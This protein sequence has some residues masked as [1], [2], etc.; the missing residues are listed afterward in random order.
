MTEKSVQSHLCMGLTGLGSKLTSRPAPRVLLRLNFP[1]AGKQSKRIEDPGPFPHKTS[2]ES[3]ILQS[4]CQFHSDFIQFLL[5]SCS[6]LLLVLIRRRQININRI[7]NQLKINRSS[8]S[9]SGW[10]PFHFSPQINNKFSLAQIT[11][12]TWIFEPIGNN[13]LATFFH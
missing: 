1:Y 6:L 4:H 9:S 7:M 10:P 8:W 12:E 2:R 5:F 3:L 13:F 11:I